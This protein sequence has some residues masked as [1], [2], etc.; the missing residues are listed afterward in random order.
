MLGVQSRTR[1]KPAVNDVPVDALS[2][3]DVRVNSLFKT[4][5]RRPNLAGLAYN[6][7]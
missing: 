3:V 1:R 5:Q 6:V 4:C 2:L 7:C